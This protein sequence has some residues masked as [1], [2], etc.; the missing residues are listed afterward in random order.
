MS[1]FFEGLNP[2]CN[3][4]PHDFIAPFNS[5]LG[6]IYFTMRYLGTRAIGDQTL[7]KVIQDPMGF[8]LTRP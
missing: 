8:W 3:D 6:E 1:E 7:Q 5:G 2:I 4:K